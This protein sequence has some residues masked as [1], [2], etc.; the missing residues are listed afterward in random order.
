MSI[1]KVSRMGHPVLR[2]KVRPVPPAEITAAPIQRLI[3]DMTQTMLEY[4]GVGLAAPQVHEELRV[5]VAQVF[6]DHEEDE[7]DAEPGSLKILALINPEIKPVGRHVEEDWEGC[8]SIPDVRG[9]VPRHRDISV[10]AYDR[11][12]RPIEMQASGFMAR[13]IQHETDHLD[14]VLFLD[15]MKSLDSLSFIEEYARYHAKREHE[16]R[17]SQKSVVSIRRQRT[18]HAS[19]CWRSAFVTGVQLGASCFWLLASD[20]H[21]ATRR[22]DAVSLSPLIIVFVTVFI[23]LLGFGIIIPLLPFYAETFGATA[24]T[25]GLLA[26]SFSLMQF[27]FAPIWG[28]LSDRVGRRP[29][30]LLG[31]L[32]SCLSY[33]AFGMASTLTAALRRPDLRRHRR[34]EH[35]DRP[36]RRGRPDHPREPG[37]GHGDGGGGVRARV[38]LRP[39]HRGLPEPLRVRG[40]GVL[41]VGAVA[42]QFRRRLV[43]PAR[44]AEAR[45]PGYRAR[46]PDRRAAFGPREAASSAAAGHRLPGRGGLLGLRVHLRA[47]RRA[48]LRLPRVIDRLRVRLRRHRP[49][50]RP[51]IPRRQGREEDRRAPHRSRRRSRL[52]RSA[53]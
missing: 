20:R 19:R 1:L 22:F 41:R 48:S 42:R 18:C 6:R 30:I 21:L 45:A 36:G 24:F 7:E 51:G 17:S 28:R 40:A 9:L 34:R 10:K 47:L 50:D 37:E 53:C 26:T 2:K 33:L 35:P 46:R 43:P 12:G 39:G 16:G 4:N 31:L 27:I 8:L 25:V 32:G 13:V 38:H 44:D 23:D 3:D 52:W 11:T 5:F 29:I 15:R 14:G 49:G